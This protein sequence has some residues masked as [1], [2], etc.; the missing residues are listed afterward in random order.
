[1][2]DIKIRQHQTVAD[3]I[4]SHAEHTS[5]TLVAATPLVLRVGTDN[6]MID[7]KLVTMQNL[8]GGT[9]YFGFDSTIDETNGTA[10]KGKGIHKFAFGPAVDIYVYFAS[11]SDK[12]LRI[13]E[14][15]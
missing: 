3:I 7:R 15:R 5:K 2:S 6:N 10:L 8:T 12:D 11:G 14:G 13:T 4:L 1:M 9:I